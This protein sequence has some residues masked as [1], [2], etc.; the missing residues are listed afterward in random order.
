MESWL[1]ENVM[2]R[3]C[4][5][6]ENLL[7]VL[8]TEPDLHVHLFRLL[9]HESDTVLMS[10]LF[11]LCREEWLND[12]IINRVQRLFDFWYGQNG[13]YH[14]LWYS[15]DRGEHEDPPIFTNPDGQGNV[16]GQG[17]VDGAEKLFVIVN[18]KGHWGV[19]EMDFK[20]HTIRSADSLDWGVTAETIDGL[21]NWLVPDTVQCQLWAAAKAAV[22]SLPIQKQVDSS[23]CGLYALL[24]IEWAVN[25]FA[26]RSFVNPIDLRIRFLGHASGIF[27]VRLHHNFENYKARREVK[28]D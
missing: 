26:D 5:L 28:L 3:N 10:D 12:A 23:S 4:Y 20:D 7:V 18:M 9:T 2:K 11:T 24:A 13:R 8:R 27:L 21:V 19:V 15:A 22:G 25:P 14:F 1:V 17:K 16:D 6:A